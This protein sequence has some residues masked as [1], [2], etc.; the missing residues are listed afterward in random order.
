[1][2][3]T[4][5]LVTISAGWPSNEAMLS[6]A[7]NSGAAPALEPAAKAGEVVSFTLQP[8]A[9]EAVQDL[10]R[11]LAAQLREHS[12]TPLHLLAF[13]KVAAGAATTAALRKIFGRVDWP[14]TCVEGA[15]CDGGPIAGI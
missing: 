12:A 13:G 14:M 3:S 8:T 5:C 1:M 11:R 6:L 7:A 9:G 15:A 4:V 10:C 2:V